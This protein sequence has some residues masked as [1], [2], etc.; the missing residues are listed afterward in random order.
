M[1]ENALLHFTNLD[2]VRGSRTLLANIQGEFAPGEFVAIVG[3]NGCGKSSML[4]ALSGIDVTATSEIFFQGQRL[5]RYGMAELARFRAVMQQAPATPFGFVSAEILEM[6]RSQLRES[7]QHRQQCIQ[8]VAKWFEISHLLTRNIQ[9]LS[10]GERQRVFLAKTLLQ[11]LPTT[12]LENGA[13]RG[14]LLLLDEPTSALDLR[15]Q[16]IVMQTLSRLCQAGLCI[17]CVSHDI[18]LITPYASR[19]MVLGEK[20]CLADA[21]PA[22]ALNKDVLARCFHTQLQLLQNEHQTVFVTH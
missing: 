3:E 15:H 22:E 14:R 19:M 6:A 20:R 16:K 11:I 9:S 1:S 5:H 12:E 13:L 7:P 21:P 17:L 18:N 10:G 4:S 8:Q 2:V